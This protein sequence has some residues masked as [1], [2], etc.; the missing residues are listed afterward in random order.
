MPGMLSSWAE[1]SRI[2][3]EFGAASEPASYA[4]IH[5]FAGTIATTLRHVVP[6]ARLAPADVL[7]ANLASVKSQREV[8]RIRTACQIAAKAFVDGS[9]RF[10][11]G[12]SEFEAA[13]LVRGGFEGFASVAG[14]ERGG[15]F[16]WCMSGPN[17]AKAA[18]SYARSRARN[19]AVGDLVL[20]HA[21]S[22]ADGYW[23][24]ITRT[25]VLGSPDA[26]QRELFAAVFAARQAALEAI[27]PGVRASQVDR[28]ARKTL[29][30]LGFGKEF[31]HSTGHGV[32][33]SAISAN[34]IPR[35]HPAS[36]EVLESG[37]V[38]NLEPAIYLDGYGGVRHCDVV[39]VGQNGAELLTTFQ[40]DV[41][42]LV[43]PG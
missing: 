36:D 20:L 25:Y 26:K 16:A 19:L 41:A 6:R 14:V 24:D 15:G 22:H 43:L 8:E 13:S 30:G 27:R 34:A 3:F 18:A 38:F 11:A 12:M 10:R 28:S 2:G 23:T 40:C 9:S 5:L 31:K 4:A 29:A 33:F 39:A 21:N 17:S 32:G 7:L 35:I 37:M 1:Q 42:D